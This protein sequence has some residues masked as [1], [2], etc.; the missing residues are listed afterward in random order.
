MF[1]LDELKDAADIVHEVMP[2]TPQYAWPLLARR[3]GCEVWV[4]HE[5]H[6]PIGAF[7]IRGGLVFL[8]QLMKSG[9]KIDGMI[10]ATRGNHGQSI[11]LACDRY[12]I[13]ATIYVPDGNSVEKNKA[14]EAFGANLVVHGVDFDEAREEAGRVALAQNLYPVPSFHSWL[15]RG[16]ATYALEFFSAVQDLD[17]VYAPIGMGSGICGLISARDLLG[18]RTKIVGVVAQNAPAYVMSYEAGEVCETNSA[19][20]FADGMACRVPSGEALEI[21][22]RG[23]ERLVTVSED[24]IASA[25][26]AYYSDTH[27]LAEGAGAASL[28]ALLNESAGMSGKKVGVILS[29]GNVDATPFNTVLNG[30]TPQLPRVASE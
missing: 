17:T 9:K 14:M 18:L 6:T 29:G 25:M 27:N 21:I 16:V 20:T 2:P 12:K 7:K 8:D 19:A 26:R 24:E 1:T 10:T 22:C 30:G 15:V 4:K 28:A 13:P 23:A 11:A 5:N 3:T